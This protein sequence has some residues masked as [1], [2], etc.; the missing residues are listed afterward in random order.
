MS[1]ALNAH[2]LPKIGCWIVC[3]W[4]GNRHAKRGPRT[5]FVTFPRGMQWMTETLLGAAEAEF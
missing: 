2:L 3:A 5:I 4:R 1:A